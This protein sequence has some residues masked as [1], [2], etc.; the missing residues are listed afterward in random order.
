MAEKITTVGGTVRQDS[1]H[2]TPFGY[3]RPRTVTR[4]IERPRLAFSPAPP[5][6]V[7][8][9]PAG[10]GKTI[11]LSQWADAL[12]Q[13]EHEVVWFRLAEFTEGRHE[14]W[15]LLAGAFGLPSGPDEP[16]EHL[17]KRLLQHCTGLRRPTFLF[18]DDYQTATDST[19]DAM[20]AE[21]VQRS[22]HLHLVVAARHFALLD[23]PLVTSKFD[24]R[25]VL[26]SELTFTLEE[27]CELARR[28][29]WED[30]EPV[31]A[32]HAQVG[33]WPLVLQTALA[34]GNAEGVD[35]ANPRGVFDRQLAG[36]AEGFLS[37]VD[38]RHGRLALLAVALCPGISLRLVTE[39]V[40]FA[41]GGAE[42][43]PVPQQS[44][45]RIMIRLQGLGL[46]ERTHSFQT[47]RF[48]CHPG[49]EGALRLRA[50]DEIEDGCL[51]ELTS[52]HASDLAEDDPP[53]AF[54]LLCEIENYEAAEIVMRR[55]F[56][57]ILS[58]DEA[59]RAALAAIPFSRLFRHLALSGARVLFAL[60][61]PLIPDSTVTA[62]LEGIR[63]TA[64]QAVSGRD[65]GAAFPAIAVLAGVEL[66]L[67]NVAD[68][69]RLAQD[70]EHR[71]S[72]DARPGA[73]APKEIQAFTLNII[74]LVG[75]ANG[76]FALANRNY[77]AAL[78]LAMHAGSLP[79]QIR[80]LQGLALAAGIVGDMESL[81]SYLER[82]GQIAD[83]HDE[84]DFIVEDTVCAQLIAACERGDQQRVQQL[85]AAIQPLLS[86]M[87]TAPLIVMTQI[88]TVRKHSGTYSA[89]TAL[90]QRVPAGWLEAPEKTYFT[91]LLGVF[92]ADLNTLLGNFAAAEAQLRRMDAEQPEVRLARARVQFF[93]GDAQ[94]S[95]RTVQQ[96]QPPLNER[97]QLECELLT[98]LS[99][100][101]LGFADDAFAALDSATRR[102][103]ETSGYGSLLQLPFEPLRQLA[104][105]AA[106]R[107]RESPL[108]EIEAIPETLRAVQIE[109]LTA[110][111]MRALA[112][113]AEGR[114]L[115]ET[116]QLMYVSLN[117]LKFHLRSIY[118]KLHASNREEAVGRATR[119]GL[120]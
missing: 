30:E 100:W 118:R 23:G 73:F 85:S 25:I 37:T 19:T 6:T 119:M 95:L 28:C 89:L 63:D 10:Y 44:V 8:T 39:C 57:A 14:F 106:E 78:K 38:Q 16:S 83:H 80:A 86:R 88:M 104:E 56:I 41:D 52:A 111:E 79:S 27:A 93:G 67:G 62:L 34:A 108:Q 72:E 3:G 2:E 58:S 99:S 98:A 24:V 91:R 92:A 33:G 110:A 113:L 50:H 112:V 117:T 97:L 20:L 31:R 120:V 116:A 4:L 75:L 77:R 1:A 82:A 90:H 13:E 35:R 9:A 81:R 11:A 65:R 60:S 43:E 18:I 70:L 64:R 55:H 36:L 101:Q 29:G 105:E 68:S 42:A 17:R 48:R 40:R 47:Q 15:R 74:G 102:M 5:L 22:R 94:G 115:E 107:G 84:A 7:F 54:R 53:S 96:L 45:D 109:P 26:E 71:L 69:L 46:V 59:T 66:Y 103:A 49:L 87:V 32:L 12:E 61:D 51:R 114:P 21:L 76:D